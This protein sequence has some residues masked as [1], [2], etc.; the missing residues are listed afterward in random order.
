MKS[1]WSQWG[2]TNAGFQVS[3]DFD[4]VWRGARSYA[5]THLSHGDHKVTRQDRSVK[6]PETSQRGS[7]DE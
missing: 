3:T 2:R 5:L 4:K 7:K 6:L 1:F